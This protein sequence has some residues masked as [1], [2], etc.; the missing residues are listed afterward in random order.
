[1]VYLAR[2][3]RVTRLTRALQ[4]PRR[5][6]RTRAWLQPILIGCTPRDSMINYPLSPTRHLHAKQ[7][8]R[9]R[10]REDATKDCNICLPPLHA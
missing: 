6:P 2:K 3:I 8:M 5:L 9:A 4:I 1:M 10:E 7:L